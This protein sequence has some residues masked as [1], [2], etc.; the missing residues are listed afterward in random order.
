MFT[1][2]PGDAT[3]PDIDGPVV[4][5]HVLSTTGAYGKGFAADLAKRHPTAK[6][7]YQAWAKGDPASG[8][9]RAFRLGAVQ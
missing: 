4:I 5:A 6:T 1:Q 7:R 2:R 3:N 9:H 8:T